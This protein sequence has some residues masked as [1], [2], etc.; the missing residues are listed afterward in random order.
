MA[1]SANTPQV[2]RAWTLLVLLT[3]A[4][5]GAGHSGLPDFA[6][7]SLILAGAFAK[8]RWML[9]DFIKLRGAPP[10][11]QALFLTWMVVAVLV[12]WALGALEALALIRG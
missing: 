12:P 1:Q 3:V 11:W 6:A 2:T 10:G 5:L 9:M 7:D 8:G 4:S